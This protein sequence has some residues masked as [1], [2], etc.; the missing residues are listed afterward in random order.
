MINVYT[1]NPNNPC[2]DWKRPCFGGAKA[3]HRAQTGSRCIYVYIYIHS[4]VK[5]YH[6]CVSRSI[7]ILSIFHISCDYHIYI[8]IFVYHVSGST[9]FVPIYIYIPESSRPCKLFQP[10]K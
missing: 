4:I 2:F 7:Q 6:I 10:M 1:W 3:Q 5:K 8:Y 9:C